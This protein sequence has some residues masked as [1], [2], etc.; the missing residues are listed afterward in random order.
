MSMTSGL[1]FF[2]FGINDSFK[3]LIKTISPSH[4]EN[5]K[6]QKM[7]ITGFK[8]FTDSVKPGLETC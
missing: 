3:N 1:A 2:F 4:S 5:V 6:I 8:W 7:N